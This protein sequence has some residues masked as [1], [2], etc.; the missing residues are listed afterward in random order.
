MAMRE[1][2]T[3]KPADVCPEHLLPEIGPG[4]NHKTFGVCLKVNG[5]SE[6]FIPV[7]EGLTNIAFAPDHGHAL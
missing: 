3:V 4:I 2:N 7:V 5:T 6:S 1:N